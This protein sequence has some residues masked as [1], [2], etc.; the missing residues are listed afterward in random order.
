MKCHSKLLPEI[1][2]KAMSLGLLDCKNII[3]EVIAEKC[4]SIQIG[5]SLSKQAILKRLNESI[6]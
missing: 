6:S 4:V 3:E 2:E 1:F 5:V